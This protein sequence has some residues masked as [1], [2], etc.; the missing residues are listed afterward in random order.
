MVGNIEEDNKVHVGHH[1]V[2]MASLYVAL[3]VH[4]NHE[5]ALE[6]CNLVAGKFVGWGAIV[7][8]RF[9]NGC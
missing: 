2:E 1:M 7:P 3:V 9:K 4:R 8:I 5:V 6:A